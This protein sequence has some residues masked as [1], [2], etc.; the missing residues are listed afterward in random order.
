M[1][2][3]GL[4]FDIKWRWRIQKAENQKIRITGMGTEELKATD[5]LKYVQAM[6]DETPPAKPVAMKLYMDC[7][8]EVVSKI[9]RLPPDSRTTELFLNAL[10][11]CLDSRRSSLGKLL[12]SEVVEDSDH[13][14]RRTAAMVVVYRHRD[15]YEAGCPSPDCALP[16][17]IPGKGPC[18][19]HQPKNQE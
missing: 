10:A 9:D 4:R 15:F 11:K 19:Y 16:K 18:P 8:A 17:M 1:K 12:D 13:L 2:V 5:R 3:D 7:I 14:L 6:W